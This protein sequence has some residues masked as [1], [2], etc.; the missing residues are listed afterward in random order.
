MNVL[1]WDRKETEPTLAFFPSEN[2][3]TILGTSIPLI[4]NIPHLNRVVVI[5]TNPSL[6][7]SLIKCY[8][9]I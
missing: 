2:G 9:L 3:W 1:L 6:C 4:Q 5:A 7:K 8:L